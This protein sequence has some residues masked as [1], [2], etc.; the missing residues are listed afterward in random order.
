MTSIKH[1]TRRAAPRLAALTAVL[2][3]SLLA[4]CSSYNGLTGRIAQHITPYRVTIV[5][6][7]F[8]SSEAA[9]KLHVGMTREQVRGA[10]GTPLLVDMFHPERWDYVF[11]FRRGST[12]VVEQRDLVVHF[13]GDTVTGWTG[14]EDLPS[15][16]ELI[17]MIDGDRRENTLVRQKR[18]SATD[19]AQDRAADA[20]G[21]TP[22]GQTA[23]APVAAS[24]VEPA[25]RRA[26]DTA[27]QR[28]DAAQPQ[29]TPRG[30]L[31]NAP[32]TVVRSG[33]QSAVQGAPEPQFQFTT[34]SHLH[35]ASGS[36]SL[37]Q[38]PAVDG[39]AAP[40]PASSAQ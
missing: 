21:Q 24:G 36:S 30:M 27:N 40:S 13:Q 39:A 34:P 11:Y 4:A 2:G 9:A 5:Q 6:G 10:L 37:A 38:P 3:A 31:R 26:A 14:A 28:L 25:N 32:Q 29:A 33:P 22:M 12:K 7:N 1:T 16:Q 8:V 35:P 18:S 19:A 17:A 20:A 23:S 15:E